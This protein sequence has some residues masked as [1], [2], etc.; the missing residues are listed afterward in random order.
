MSITAFAAADFPDDDHDDPA[1][2]DIVGLAADDPL[3]RSPLDGVVEFS[4]RPSPTS[5]PPSVASATPYLTPGEL[6]DRLQVSRTHGGRLAVSEDRSAVPR[7]RPQGPV[8]HRRCLFLGELSL[9]AGTVETWRISQDRRYRKDPNGKKQRT[10]YSGNNPYRVRY[11]GPDGKE[12]NRSFSLARDAKQYMAEVAVGMAKGNWVDPQHGKMD[13]G[14]WIERWAKSRQGL[15]PST[16][17]RDDSHLRNHVL[18]RWESVPLARVEYIDVQEWIADLVDRDYAADT[19]RRIVNL[20]TQ[21]MREAVKAQK[22]ASSPCEGLSLPAIIRR[23][24][25]FLEP[26]EVIAL[27]DAIDPRYRTLVITGAIGGFRPG[28][29]LGLRVASVNPLQ[30]SITVT[31]TLHD[32]PTGLR[33]G[34]PKTKASYRTVAVPATV[35][36]EI[37]PLLHHRDLQEPLFQ[38]PKG[39]PIRINGFRRRF[40]N[41]ATAR[42][43]LG[44]LWMHGLRHTAVSTWIHEGASSI[45]VAARAGHRSVVT[46]LDRYGHLFAELRTAAQRPPRHPLRSR[47]GRGRDQGPGHQPRPLKTGRPQGRGASCPPH[48]RRRGP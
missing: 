2:L 31:E 7:V 4:P 34:P 1:V 5:S 22:L 35:M 10:D 11:R 32:E 8:P 42:A 24:I 14:P 23:A 44:G 16:I 21:A 33:Y 36:T 46:V 25:R 39:G 19:V 20:F 17:A 18:P 45:E 12:H 41:P 3:D 26:H 37:E 30:S 6:A 47:R 40:W 28:E 38:A 48:H 29:L 13:C 27:A 43:G 15:R 9:I